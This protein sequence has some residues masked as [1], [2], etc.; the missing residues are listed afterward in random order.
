[1]IPFNRDLER[2]LRRLGVKIS[3]I[4]NV[5]TVLIEAGDKEI[6]LE[7]PQVMV[8]E[9]RGQKIYQIISGKEKIISLTAHQE[10]K[11]YTDEDIEF[12]MSQ[13]GLSREKAKELLEKAGGDIAKA[14]MIYE[15]EKK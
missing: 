7:D 12:I 8:M 14:L 6:V 15:E 3:N 13:T 11:T 10:T 1:M 9:F 4:D 2:Q 5:K